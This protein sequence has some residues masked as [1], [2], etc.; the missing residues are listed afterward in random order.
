MGLADLPLLRLELGTD[1]MEHL[2][3]CKRTLQD[4]MYLERLAAAPRT[5][6]LA[7]TRLTWWH[8]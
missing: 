7:L 1:D 2:E 5:G 6:T 3:A 4:A 8:D